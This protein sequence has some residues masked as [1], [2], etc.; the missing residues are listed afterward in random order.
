MLTVYTK[1]LD[2]GRPVH[3]GQV[4]DIKT[5]IKVVTQLLEN[6]TWIDSLVFWEKT[7]C[8]FTE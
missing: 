4:T 8:V 2:S 1:A 7:V 6:W 3:N 5:K